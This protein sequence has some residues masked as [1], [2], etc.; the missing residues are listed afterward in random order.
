M[1]QYEPFD[2]AAE[3]RGETITPLTK[4][5]SEISETFEK[6]AEETLAN[7]GITNL[8]ANEWYP[9]TSTLAVFEEIADTVGEN[10][11]REVGKQIPKEAE[12]PPSIETVEGGI[13]S[14]GEAYEMNHR[15]GEIG[16]YEAEPLEEQTVKVT[17]KNPYS[18]SFDR[19]ILK[20]VV[21]EFGDGAQSALVQEKGDSCRKD[22]DDKCVYHVT[23]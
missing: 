8:E 15:G 16:Y 23:W 3:A 7:H 18:C 19:G 10:T 6:K 20:G 14:I 11:I 12:W 4:A 1:A 9:M 5:L 22:G 21:S 13:T 2:M 17:C